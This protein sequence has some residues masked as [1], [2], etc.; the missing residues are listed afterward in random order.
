MNK[1]FW[2][3]LTLALVIIITVAL[4][5]SIVTTLLIVRAHPARYAL[6]ET[7]GPVF[8]LMGTT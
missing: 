8:D 2:D 6:A 5:I 4:V 7:A 3:W 1:A